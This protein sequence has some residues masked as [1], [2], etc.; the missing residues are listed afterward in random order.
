MEFKVTRIL[1]IATRIIIFENIKKKTQLKVEIARTLID[2]F[3]TYSGNLAK[4]A[5]PYANKV[6]TIVNTIMKM[7]ILCTESFY[8]LITASTLSKILTIFYPVSSYTY[9]FLS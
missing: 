3:D 5:T 7:L 6:I 8:S 9:L 1:H 4:K 2:I